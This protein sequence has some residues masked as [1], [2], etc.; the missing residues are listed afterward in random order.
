MFKN[1][2]KVAL[3]NMYMLGEM[4]RPTDGY[5]RYLDNMIAT[6]TAA[7]EA[8]VEKMKKQ[9]TVVHKDVEK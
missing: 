9:L 1:T 6:I 2:V 3:E 7:H 5:D 8:E 4:G